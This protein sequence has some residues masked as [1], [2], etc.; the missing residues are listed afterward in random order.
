MA[1]DATPGTTVGVT[2]L[3]TD[4]DVGATVTYALTSN[5]GNLF[6]IDAD[7]GVVTLVGALNYEAATQTFELPPGDRGYGGGKIIAR[8]E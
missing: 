4:A 3:G 1:E 2:A 7:T 6:A 5:P 8:D